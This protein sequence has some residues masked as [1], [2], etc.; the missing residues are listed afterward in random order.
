MA[1]RRQTISNS[2]LTK[3]QRHAPRKNAL[4]NVTLMDD[5]IHGM[6]DCVVVAAALTIEVD[7]HLDRDRDTKATRLF[8]YFA[9]YFTILK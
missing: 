1:K 9:V 7:K 8:V 6:C 2:R 4:T 3:S 5:S